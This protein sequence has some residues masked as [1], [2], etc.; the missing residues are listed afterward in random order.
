[1]KRAWRMTATVGMEQSINSLLVL[2]FHRKNF[3][4]SARFKGSALRADLAFLPQE[5]IEKPLKIIAMDFIFEKHKRLFL[6]AFKKTEKPCI[7]FHKELI[8]K[9][10]W[11]LVVYPRLSKPAFRFPGGRDDVCG[12]NPTD[13][14]NHI[15][16]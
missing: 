4:V 3:L 12:A 2:L 9:Y 11:R 5:T 1:M 14:K 10:Y 13:G 16:Y 6:K 15:L 7:R 8:I